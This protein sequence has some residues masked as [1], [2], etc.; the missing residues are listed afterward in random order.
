MRLR[1]R[2]WLWLG[3]VGVATATIAALNLAP[4]SR[5]PVATD[6]ARNDTAR[7][8][9]SAQ[10][11]QATQSPFTAIDEPVGAV[12]SA[13]GE[14]SQAG[15]APDDAPP[16]Q[17]TAAESVA[18]AGWTDAELEQLVKRVGRDQAL[19]DALL[20]EFSRETDPQRLRRLA[21]LLSRVGG[22]SLVDVATE[23]AYSG[24][25]PSR[26]AA[27]DMLGRIQADDPSARAVIVDLLSAETDER[28]LVDTLNAVSVASPGS[29]E[30]TAALVDQVLAL[31][32][33]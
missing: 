1:G 15:D 33:Q 23:M 12:D 24:S 10:A 18:R 19:F 32:G 25:E 5:E 2:G 30:T 31:T 14:K 21:M 6:A 20:G 29:P 17:L 13:A 7:S 9:S 28:L 11:E 26:R 16:R 4:D 8:D 27:L 22:E 3:S